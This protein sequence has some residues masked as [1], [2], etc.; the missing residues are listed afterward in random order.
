MDRNKIRNDVLEE[1]AV[2]LETHGC[3]NTLNVPITKIVKPPMY[4]NTKNACRML[5][6]AAIRKMKT[7]PG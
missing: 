4:G 5:Y 3:Y 7:P 2:F 6:A 1:A